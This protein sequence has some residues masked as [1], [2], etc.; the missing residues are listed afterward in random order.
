MHAHP[1]KPYQTIE[2][3]FWT[4]FL[5]YF[6]NDVLEFI[7]VVFIPFFHTVH[8]L[9]DAV[10]HSLVFVYVW[11]YF[12]TIFFPFS[13]IKSYSD[14][15]GKLKARAKRLIKTNINI[16][17]WA[18]SWRLQRIFRWEPKF[19]FRWSCWTE[20]LSIRLF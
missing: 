10:A 8:L 5:R 18:V 19:F 17:L 1:T 20:S 2:K 3:R 6:R 9:F 7:V 4:Q 14:R 11:C 15:K 13:S 16:Q 12:S